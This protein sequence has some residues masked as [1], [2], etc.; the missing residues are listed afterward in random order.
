MTTAN[1]VLN[2]AA[3]QIG[4]REG[5]GYGGRSNYTKFW[6]ALKPEWQGGPW[7]ATFVHWVFKE[8]GNTLLL[9]N[10]P[11]PYYT[12]SMESW[13]R[14]NGRWIASKDARPGDV[15]IFGNSSK[16]THT[17]ILTKQYD[18]DHIVAIEGN[19]SAGARGSQTDGGGVYRRVRPR[20]FIRGVISM[21]D[22]FTQAPPA[23][24]PGAP[25]P[26][27]VDGEAGPK[28][29]DALEWY[30]GLREGATITRNG[31]LDRH[32]VREL[33]QWAGRPR[34]G[35]LVR[36]D[37]RAIQRKVGAAPDGV[38]GPRTT[39]AL[40]RFLNRRIA[41]FVKAAT[42]VAEQEA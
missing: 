5:T 38:W 27:D 36:E 13:A 42:Q 23:G 21:Q 16:A 31:E 28:T 32:D 12:P 33:Q 35:I 9:D 11:M 7:C 34:T 15:V 30:L 26:L 19:A 6:A 41:E 17:G 40:Q 39:A 1:Q 22:Q 8:C 10:V 20:S 4:Y 2:K 25:A 24:P 29:F 3:S 18:R 37:V 14:A